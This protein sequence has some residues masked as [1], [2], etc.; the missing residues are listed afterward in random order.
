[1]ANIP[2]GERLQR[3]RVRNAI[4]Q[5]EL[6][7][8]IGVSGPTI[9]NWEKGKTA[10]S[11]AQRDKLKTLFGAQTVERPESKEL[12]FVSSPFAAWLTKTRL[13]KKL[14][15]PEIAEKAGLSEA[16]IYN[17]EAGRSTNPRAETVRKLERAL[18]AKLEEEVKQ[19]IQDEA[20]I[21]GLGELSNF[22]PHNDDDLPSAS[23]IYVLYDISER[24]IYV[25]QASDIKRRIRE[26][27]DKFW[28]KFPI[29]DTA[30]FVTVEDKKLRD[31][32]EAL[33]IRFLKSNAVI[34]QQHVRR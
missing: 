22:D 5:T 8:K 21:E 23:G 12:E 29:V 2:Y 24:P 13:E 6:G 10:P 25:G 17:I 15:I 14:S 30:A 11:K 3:A 9:S 34:N 16:A 26:H 4:T 19:E 33:L 18:D 28:F 31:R 27:R 7:E 20:T 1:M 32:I